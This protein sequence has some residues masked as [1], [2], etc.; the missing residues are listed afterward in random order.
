MSN[1]I[2]LSHAI[3]ANAAYDSTTQYLLERNAESIER[4]CMTQVVVSDQFMLY[5]GGVAG[6]EQYTFT[7]KE[8]ST[9]DDTCGKETMCAIYKLPFR[10]P[11]ALAG[12]V[13]AKL[14]WDGP[15]PAVVISVFTA[16]VLI[17]Q[18]MLDADVFIQN[19]YLDQIS[20]ESVTGSWQ[21]WTCKINYDKQTKWY[22]L[23]VSVLS[24]SWTADSLVQIDA[25]SAWEVYA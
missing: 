9:D 2:D 22:Y 10:G 3:T 25:F 11:N 1:V 16:P 14:W 20:V 17:G 6:N 5:S 19:Q 7:A 15:P 23:Y 8:N 24:S 4:Y 13:R 18:R 21:D 12:K